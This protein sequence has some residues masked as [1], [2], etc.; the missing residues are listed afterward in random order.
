MSVPAEPVLLVMDIVSSGSRTRDRAKVAAYA[1]GLAI[2]V[3]WPVQVH[4][5][6]AELA[7]G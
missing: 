1:E 6:L 5:S 3:D 7:R 4:A 2:E